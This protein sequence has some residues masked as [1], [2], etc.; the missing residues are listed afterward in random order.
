MTYLFATNLDIKYDKDES[1]SLRFVTSIKGVK[2]LINGRNKVVIISHRGR[3]K[4]KN[5]EL[6]LK[7]F[8]KLFESELG[9]KITFLDNSNLDRAKK[10][11]KESPNG[12]VF[13]LENTRFLKGEKEND[14]YLSKKLAS[15]GDIF[16]NDDFATA[17]RKS[18]SNVGI[19]KFIPSRMGPNFKKEVYSL[20]KVM[21]TPG[22]PFVIILGG[23]KMEDKM[24]VIRNLMPK[25]DYILLGGGVANTYLKASGANI[26]NSLYDK[27]MLNI[28][29]KLSR[30][31]KIV[32]PI[33]YKRD[34]D[35]ILDIGEKTI[36]TYSNI[37]KRAKTVIWGGPMGYYEN[38]RFAKGSYGVAKAIAKT[39]AFSVVGGGETTVIINRLK[40]NNKINLVSTGGGAMLGFLSGARMPAIEVLK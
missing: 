33:D 25:T 19:S 18:A 37:I 17:H 1:T 29:R 22:H 11:I 3:P 35:R 6:S 2:S 36:R 12:S 39:R 40:L 13:L 5:K 16:I 26:G 32:M 8:Q 20:T 14:S 31:K 10:I 15:L 23:A 21:K 38:K 9:G 4:R 24:G 28:A 30:S 7:P 27:N 34:G